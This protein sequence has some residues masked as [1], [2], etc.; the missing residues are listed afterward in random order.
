MYR[1]INKKIFHIIMIIVI[2]F[3]VLSVAGIMVLKYHVEGEANM[4][5]HITKILIVESAE[6]ISNEGATEKWNLNVNQNNDIFIYLEKNSNYGKTETIKDVQINEFNI[7]KLN[8]IGETKLYKPVTNDKEMFVNSVENEISEITY[9]G[10]LQ[11]N[12]QEQKISNQGGKIVFRYAI[13]NISKY[14]SN[15][16]EE[17]NHGQLLKLSNANIEDLKTSL[18]FNIVLTLNS[19][20]KYQTTVEVDIPSDEVIESSPYAKEITDFDDIIFKRIEN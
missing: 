16:N 5:F 20:K 19:G 18:S 17:I 4:P 15:E 9:I 3:V 1:N 6:G 13:N 2:I 11:S 12:L 7:N 14:I 8:Q 10:D